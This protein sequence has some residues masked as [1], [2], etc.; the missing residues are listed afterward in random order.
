[1]SQSEIVIQIDQSQ[2]AVLDWLVAKTRAGWR[3][4]VSLGERSKELLAEGQAQ[5][6]IF[7]IFALAAMRSPT[8]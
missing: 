2:G 6:A 4:R 8:G 1:M 3:V 5:T 7:A